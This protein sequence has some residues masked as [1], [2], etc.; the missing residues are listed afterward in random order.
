MRV[1]WVRILLSP[2]QIVITNMSDK[3]IS[4]LNHAEMEY[5]NF[6]S[7]HVHDYENSF[8]VQNRV[9]QIQTFKD[10]ISQHFNFDEINLIETGVSG[11]VGYGLFGFFLGS[12]V[13]NYGGRMASV[14][15]DCVSCGQS[16][17]IFSENFHGINYKTYCMD[18]IEFLKRP[19]F[20]PNIV[21]LDSYDLDLFNPF[22]S[23]LHH[24]KEFESIQNLMPKGGIILIDD[25]WM[26]DT[27]LQWVYPDSEI[28]KTIEYPIFGKGA[29]IYHEV[30]SNR[31]DFE[32]IGNH[33]FPGNNIKIYI[34]KIN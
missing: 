19:P 23:T 25:N 6:M 10:L 18:S 30:L 12:L 24:W 14:D 31:T 34:K 17:K 26:K 11:N 29:N 7:K 4:S 9:N 13:H 2:L 28:W 22:P 27:N 20:I 16:E 1:P 33:Y 8:L 5:K 15:T 21:H 32:L 3:L